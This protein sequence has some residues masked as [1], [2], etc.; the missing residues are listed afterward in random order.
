MTTAETPPVRAPPLRRRPSRPPARDRRRWNDR[1]MTDA[2]GAAAAKRQEHGVELRKEAP[3]GRRATPVSLR[4][5]AWG[6]AVC[7]GRFADG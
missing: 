4:Q 7:G 3:R 1:A 5:G 2:P 6:V